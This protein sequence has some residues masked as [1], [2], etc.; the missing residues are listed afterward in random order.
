MV[1]LQTRYNSRLLF[2]RTFADKTLKPL[3]P[4]VF[5]PCLYFVEG[6]PY[7]LVVL[8]SVIFYKNLGESL[9]FIGQTTSLFYLPWVLKFIWAPMVDIFGTKRQWIICAQSLLAAIFLLLI[10]A[11]L[12]GETLAVTI[13]CFSIMG[14]ISAT[15]DVAID[16][17]YLITLNKA[18]QSYFVGV[19]NA[20][21]KMAILF[22]QCVLVGLVGILHE[23]HNVPVKQAW[24]LAFGVC[25]LICA[26]SSLLNFLGLPKDDPAPEVRTQAIP[27]LVIK[28]TVDSR[29]KTFFTIFKTFFDQEKIFWTVTYILIF[30]LG[31]A[32][33][34]KMAPPFL[35]DTQANGGMG[36]SD[37]TLSGVSGIG[38]GFLLV[39]GILGGIAVSRYGLKRT[40][41]PTAIFQNLSIVLYYLLALYK[42]SFAV[43]SAF[44]AIEQFGYGLGTAAYTVFLLSTVKSNYKAGH[45]ALA[46]A[47]M[48]LGIMLPGMISGSLCTS[49]GYKTFFLVS[50]LASIPGMLTILMLPLDD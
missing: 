5:I 3:R 36:Y 38:V 9:T 10:P 12:G 37:V 16:A 1:N 18:Q 33:V 14:L 15:Q 42:P 48:A 44:N 17:F 40:L 2:G 22:G 24:A 28:Q 19:R 29:L 50:F 25:A 11:T 26:L 6:L 47:L 32:L 4:A 13:A 34:M 41:M 30:R 27:E 20:V 7:A 43:V 39:G 31:D 45:Y 21:Y 23:S 46:T 8:V 35:L 49:L